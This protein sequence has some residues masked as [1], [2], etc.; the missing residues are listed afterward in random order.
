[1]SLSV[2]DDDTDTDLLEYYATHCEDLGLQGPSLRVRLIGAKSFLERRPD[3]DAWARRPMDARLADLRGSLSPG[4]LSA[5]HCSL[6]AVRLTS[7]SS[8]RSGSATAWLV[9]L[10]FS[11]KTRSCRCV[12]PGAP[13]MTE[14]WSETVITSALPLV[15]AL[16][17]RS[18][19]TL[20]D[21]DLDLIETA[22]RDTP[23]FTGA[24][25][26]SRR[27]HLHGLRRMLYEAGTVDR[28][29]RIRHEDG[30]LSRAERL[31]VVAA[32]EIRLSILGYLDARAAVVRPATMAKLL[33]S[34]AI[35]GEF[36]TERYPELTS[37]ALARAFPGRGIL[38]LV[39]D[40]HLAGQVRG[41]PGRSLAGERGRITLR[42]FLED[43]A[44]WGWA[45]APSRRLVF[46]T[47]VPKVP[48]LLPRALPPDVDHALM[49]A[50]ADLEDLFPRRDH[51]HAAHGAPC[52]RTP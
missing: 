24:M 47:D 35:F 41:S 17:G 37:L 36:L 45:D 31:K 21:D 33:S 43:I 2:F 5:G 38:H 19:V 50:V 18:P 32:P 46:G 7:T 22:I 20:D 42:S 3:L 26:R 34:L 29:A 11:T 6:V 25:R 30:P 15:V 52:R 9:P 23:M 28:P 51:G 48:H 12:L 27:G 39:G 13:R 10:R 4:R 8:W 49:N 44:A 40:P 1:M 14:V 16:F